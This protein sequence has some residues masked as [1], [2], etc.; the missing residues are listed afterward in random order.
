MKSIQITKRFGQ[1]CCRCSRRV[2]IPIKRWAATAPNVVNDL[3]KSIKDLP[4]PKSYPLIGTMM[5]MQKGGGV[6]NLHGYIENL[7]K[8]YGKILRMSFGPVSLVVI[9]DLQDVEK[10]FRSEGKY[11]RREPEFGAWIKY[12]KSKNIQPGIFFL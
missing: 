4:G 7:T 11:P 10:L 5:D 12:H 6:T 3:P 8:Q 1:V 2:D 9:S